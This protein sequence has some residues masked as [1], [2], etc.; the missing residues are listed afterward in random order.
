MF[1]H[2]RELSTCLGF[3]TEW[4]PIRA[5]VLP[6]SSGA[7]EEAGGAT[8]APEDWDV[9]S[10]VDFENPGENPACQAHLIGVGLGR[11]E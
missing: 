6:A 8:P 10:A 5:P 1:G 9:L 11:M 2:Y 7:L 3:E 4:H